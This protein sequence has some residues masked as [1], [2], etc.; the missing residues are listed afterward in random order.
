MTLKRLM[1]LSGKAVGA[2][3]IDIRARL[4]TLCD[5]AASE[6]GLTEEMVGIVR[7]LIQAELVRRLSSSESVPYRAAFV[8]DLG[9]RLETE[10]NLGEKLMRVNPREA[11]LCSTSPDYLFVTFTNSGSAILVAYHMPEPVAP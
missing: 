5:L 2:E 10:E 4:R 1:S 3:T 6:E 9:T 11:R 8:V 7:F